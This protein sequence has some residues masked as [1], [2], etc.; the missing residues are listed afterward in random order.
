MIARDG[1]LKR[2]AVFALLLGTMIVWGCVPPKSEPPAVD[3]SSTTQ[4]LQAL[5]RYAGPKKK[6]VIGKFDSVSPELVSTK[7]ATDMM[8]TA[9]MK[10][11]AFAV[12]DSD[13][14]PAAKAPANGTHGKHA[15]APPYDLILTGRVSE[16]NANENVE[17]THLTVG[18]MESESDQT[19][20]GIGVDLR[21][22]DATTGIVVGSVN[23]RKPVQ[24]TNSETKGFGKLLGKYV[25]EVRKADADLDTSHSTKE[26]VDAALRACIEQAVVELVR[27]LPDNQSVSAR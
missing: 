26:S 6:V 2:S 23:V 18:G 19:A 17:K 11:G 20:N 21:I 15:A 14:L 10:S 9:L 24:D 25:K 8:I 13:N 16:A 4:A 1:Q 27:S 3:A 12:L 7:A 5:P 22:T